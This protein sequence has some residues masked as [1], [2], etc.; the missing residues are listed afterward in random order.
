[1]NSVND[2]VRRFVQLITDLIA[3]IWNF[4]IGQFVILFNH[5]WGSLPFWKTIIVIVV[6]VVVAYYLWPHILAFVMKLIDLLV[7]FLY[8]IPGIL[9]LGAL[10]WLVNWFIRAVHIPALDNLFK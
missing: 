1:M 10:V 8:M 3:T 7:A 6:I 5:S 4:A 2:F 9:V